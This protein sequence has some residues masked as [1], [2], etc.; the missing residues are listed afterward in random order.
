MRFLFSF[1]VKVTRQAFNPISKA[2]KSNSKYIKNVSYEFLIVFH[3]FEL[4]F[5]VVRTFQNI[6]LKL[7]SLFI[8]FFE[9]L[10]MQFMIHYEE[11]EAAI[12]KCW[13]NSRWKFF[14]KF[15]GEHQSRNLILINFHISN[16]KFYQKRDSNT[17][18][19]FKISSGQLLLITSQGDHFW[20]H[21]STNKHV[22]TNKDSYIK[23][24]KKR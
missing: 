20:L 8:Y 1:C 14:S 15:T 17:D 2:W 21:I 3:I 22:V 19:I 18:V 9:V 13:K 4:S 23:Q 10:E 12:H 5:Q 24:K 11:S 6:D 7:Q 16:L